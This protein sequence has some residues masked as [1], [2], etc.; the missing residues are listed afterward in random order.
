MVVG[1]GVVAVTNEK[2]FVSGGVRRGR[3][4]RLLSSIRGL[5]AGIAGVSQTSRASLDD[6]ALSQHIQLPINRRG[7]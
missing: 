7:S 3:P 5:N 4:Q 1:A 6:D 2:A